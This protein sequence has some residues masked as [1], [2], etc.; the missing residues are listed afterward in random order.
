METPS[1]EQLVEELVNLVEWMQENFEA[2]DIL[3]PGTAE[4]GMEVRLQ[5]TE[6]DW[7]VHHGDSRFDLDHSGCWSMAWLPYDADEEKCEEVAEALLEEVEEEIE[8]AG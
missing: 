5:V 4:S 8:N 6:E 2:S 1:L 7:Q 3:D